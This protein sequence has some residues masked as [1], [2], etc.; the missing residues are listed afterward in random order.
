MYS[1]DEKAKVARRE[2]LMRERVYDRW[3]KQGKMSRD[4]AAHEIAVMTEIA[5][6]Y[7]EQAKREQL[8]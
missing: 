2:A 3:V 4:K 6:D 7:L 8:L 1:A 5:N